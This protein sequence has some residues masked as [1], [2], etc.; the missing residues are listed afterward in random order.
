MLCGLNVISF[1]AHANYGTWS[2]DFACY[3][4][5]GKVSRNPTYERQDPIRNQNRKQ[6]GKLVFSFNQ[7]LYLCI[8]IYW[9]KN[10]SDIL[11]AC[12]LDYQIRYMYT[13]LSFSIVTL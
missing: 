4:V 10:Q 9:L 2:I 5:D 13:Y 6:L 1:Q 11:L 8:L 3:N 12:S 7:I